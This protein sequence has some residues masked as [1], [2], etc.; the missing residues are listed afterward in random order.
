MLDPTPGRTEFQHY[1][2]P[3]KILSKKNLFAAWRDSRDATSNPGR[4]G[5]DGLTAEQFSHRLE[6]RLAALAADLRS[7]RYHPSKLRAI[8]IP[9]QH[10]DKDRL[11]CIPV[12]R[13]RLVQRAIVDYLV[14]KDKLSI[15]NEFSYGFVRGRGTAHAIA[16]ALELRQKYEWCL[17]TDIEAFFDRIP[18]REAKHR[19]SAALRGSS[20]TPLVHSFVDCEIKA[21]K[22]TRPKLKKQGIV[23]GVG[24]RQGMPLS[25]LLANLVLKD[26]D[27]SFRAAQIEMVRY[28]DDLLLFFH[29]KALA[30][31]GF[32]FVRSQLRNQGLTIPDLGGEGSKSQIVAPK[33]AVTFLG[34]E[35]LYADAVGGY[36]KRVGRKQI[37]KIQQKLEEEFSFDNL[38]KERVGFQQASIGLWRTISSYLNIY[39][40]TYDFPTLDS[41]LRHA[42]RRVLANMFEDVFGAGVLNR[43]T[44]EG[45]EFLGLGSLD[46]PDDN[47]L[48]L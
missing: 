35:L 31:D 24:L 2:K 15:E 33:Q 45:R 22:Y 30:E 48:D 18:R 47:G 7:G 11:I 41:E 16:R 1:P 42:G 5:V 21:T 43:V 10:S 6:D 8:F 4:P 26:F 9:K 17:K 27:A 29:S 14:T 44:P 36:V 38:R 37:A 23:P 28:A 39:R 40:G 3:A 13:D 20:I 19:V 46:V 34:L 25:P 32:D 12:I